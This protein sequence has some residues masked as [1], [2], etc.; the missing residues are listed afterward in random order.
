MYYLTLLF[1]QFSG[2]PVKIQKNLYM[3]IFSSINIEN[4]QNIYDI[5]SFQILPEYRNYR[6]KLV[7]LRR[8]FGFPV[9]PVKIKLPENYRKITEKLAGNL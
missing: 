5:K 9:F 3:K 8:W 4:N 1:F 2:I 6:K 7:V